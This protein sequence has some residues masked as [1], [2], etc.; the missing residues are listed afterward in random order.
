MMHDGDLVITCRE[1]DCDPTAEDPD[2]GPNNMLRG[3]DV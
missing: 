1:E 2:L 3:K